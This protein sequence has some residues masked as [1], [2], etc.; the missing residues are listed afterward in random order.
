MGGG[1]MQ[2]MQDT[3][4]SFKYEELEDPEVIYNSAVKEVGESIGSI[5]IDLD[6]RAKYHG[7]TAS[8]EVG[9]RSPGL[10]PTCRA[11]RT[12]AHCVTIVLPRP[13]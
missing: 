12:N 4:A 6:G 5:S 8:S 3:V 11:Y 9:R 2:G 1:P 7:Q 10:R 13:A